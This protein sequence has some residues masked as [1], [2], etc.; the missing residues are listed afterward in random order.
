MFSTRPFAVCLALATPS[1]A[2]GAPGPAAMAMPGT[3][4][5]MWLAGA[6]VASLAFAAVGGL[7]LRSFSRSRR[8]LRGL[9][10]V[11]AAAAKVAVGEPAELDKTAG[12]AAE[13]FN[14]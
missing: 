5:A 10:A 3:P 13:P 7:A 12:P 4:P 8:R 1:L 14:A 9:N 6:G 11:A 2:L